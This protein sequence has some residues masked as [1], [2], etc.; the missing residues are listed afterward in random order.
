MGTVHEPIRS[1]LVGLPTK[2]RFLLQYFAQSPKLFLSILYERCFSKLTGCF[3][4][5]PITPESAGMRYRIVNCKS[6]SQVIAGS[7]AKIGN[8][9]VGDF[10]PMI[11]V[12]E[13]IRDSLIV[14]CQL[15][16]VDNDLP[17]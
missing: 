6:L 2:H 13:L 7:I 4:E 9:T 15:R 5:P 17:K 3:K 14:Y 16:I 11:T 8:A 1:S 10:S 12:H